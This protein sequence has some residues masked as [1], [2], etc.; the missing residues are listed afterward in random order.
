MKMFHRDPMSTPDSYPQGA[1]STLK[2]HQIIGGYAV[3]VGEWSP[4]SL[5]LNDLPG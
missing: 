1:P 5:R 3:G 2:G 4:F